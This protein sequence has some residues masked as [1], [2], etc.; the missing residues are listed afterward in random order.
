M[1]STQ[2]RPSGRRDR[3]GDRRTSAEPLA[4][5]W[6]PDV[7]RSARD[8]DVK[9][10]AQE[11]A[12]GRRGLLAVYGWRLYA[13]PLLL[14]LSLFIVLDVA[15]SPAAPQGDVA[16]GNA[17]QGRN[18]PAEDA[19]PPEN[20]EAGSAPDPA[21]NEAMPGAQFDPSIIAAELPGGGPFPETGNRSYRVLPGTTEMLGVATGDT[22]DYTVEVEDGLNV[23]VDEDG[24]STMVQDTLS[25]ERSWIGNGHPDVQNIGIRRVDETSGVVPDFRVILVSQSLAEERCSGGVE[26][27]ASC[28]IEEMV[29]LNAARWVRGARDFQGETTR[30]RQYLINHEVGHALGRR[31]HVPCA[32]DGDPAPIMMQQS[33]SL[34]NDV[35]AQLSPQ[36]YVADGKVCEPNGWP[37]P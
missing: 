12:R 11:E 6:R 19:T 24:F 22:Y 18:E 28:R 2:R 5:D 31:Q 21:V 33:W 14:V 36:A 7:E 32:V 9:S 3:R 30:Y 13:L 23:P 10:R 16:L 26:Y 29:Y 4:A 34:S 35:L 1:A 20:G 15:R 27:E 37:A 25:D 8:R 17:G